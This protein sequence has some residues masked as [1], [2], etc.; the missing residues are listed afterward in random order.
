[1]YIIDEV[2]SLYKKF[3]LDSISEH[4]TNT[5]PLDMSNHF[6]IQLVLH[7]CSLLLVN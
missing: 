3:V 2:L 7:M 5:R 6:L 4:D 1:M